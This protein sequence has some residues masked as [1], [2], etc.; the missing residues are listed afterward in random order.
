[1][2]DWVR[3]DEGQRAQFTLPACLIIMDGFGLD[4]PSEINAI[5]VAETPTLDA[6][7]AE[8][9]FTRLHASGERV[10]LPAGQMGNSEVGHLNIGAGRIVYQ[11]LTR[12]DKASSEGTIGQAPAIVDAFAAARELGSAL[13]F[14]GLLSDGGV[15]SNNKHLYAL[16][17]AAKAAGVR[18]VYVHC[19][20]DGRDVP[21]KSGAGYVAQ[22]Q[23]VI[24]E[25]SDDSCVF[26][27]ASIEGRYYAMDRDKNWE[28]I[29]RAWDTVVDAQALCD[30]SPV[31]AM[32]RS[33][34]AG[35]TDEFVEP[36]ALCD[37]GVQD[38]DAVVF[39]NFRP[40][41]A[42]Q[43]TRAFVDTDFAGFER[44]RWPKV[45]FVCLTEY[46][47]TIDAP[48]AFAKEFPDNVLADVLSAAGLAQYHIAE[49]EKYAHVTFFLNGGREEP[50][51]GEQR[52]L[53]ASPKVATYDLQPEMSEPEV[54]QAL[55]DAIDAG[56]ADVYIVNFA[57]CDMVGHTGVMDAAVQAVQ[58]VD[59]GVAQV[60]AALERKGGVALL[61]ADHGNADRM[62]A[63][64][65][66]PHTAHTTALVPLAL[67]DFAEAGYSLKDEVGALCNIAPTLLDMIGLQPPSQM[68]G[69]SLLVKEKEN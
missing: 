64:D 44:K 14:M 41:R 52:M 15:H 34:D 36:V 13:H 17:R 59:A 42:R 43:L 56:E 53:I 61:T 63:E 31:Q 58:A 45:H 9:P 35:V 32:R 67:L 28:R 57:N 65:G 51:P 39:F 66:S 19:F 60:L 25:L 21:P 12:L 26:S 2:S 68:E 69:T 47:P 24:E 20:M 11:E 37:R 33:Y 40:D 29:E 23:E 16:M 5:S 22:L 55:A 30:C 10:G 4:E 62:V 3:L 8:R 27:I 46:D 38:G 50:K 54:A 18:E 7:F 49:T 1:M 6:V 48:I